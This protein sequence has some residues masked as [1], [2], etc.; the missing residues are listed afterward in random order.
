MIAI[1]RVPSTLAITLIAVLVPFGDAFAQLCG[2]GYNETPERCDAWYGGSPCHCWHNSSSGERDRGE[3]LH[4]LAF[5]DCGW[6]GEGDYD[7]VHFADCGTI[8]SLEDLGVSMENLASAVQHRDAEMLNRMVADAAW[9]EYDVERNAILVYTAC[10]FY[11]GHVIAHIPLPR[12]SRTVQFWARAA[13]ARQN[14][15]PAAIALS[16]GVLP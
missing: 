16:V 8:A 1:A 10:S 15:W 4:F 12:D 5:G 13:N 6:F 2:T 7:M 11:N 9:W 14:V 3:D